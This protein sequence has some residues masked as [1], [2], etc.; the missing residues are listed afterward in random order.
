M[1]RRGPLSILISAQVSP[2][3]VTVQR[4]DARRINPSG[5]K[6]LSASWQRMFARTAAHKFRLEFRYC[7][8]FRH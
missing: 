2:E 7:T 1:S 4:R 5:P 3:A 6:S 8:A